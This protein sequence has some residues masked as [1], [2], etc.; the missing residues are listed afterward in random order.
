MEL[1][2]DG[3]V[4]YGMVWYGEEMVLFL[5]GDC[6]MDG[7]VEGW[8]GGKNDGGGRRDEGRGGKDGW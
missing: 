6:G 4:W 7:R 8:K 2:T 1:G 5:E 3:V